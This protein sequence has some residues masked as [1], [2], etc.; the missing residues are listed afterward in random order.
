M[1][2]LIYKYLRGDL[3]LEEQHKLSKWLE[4]DAANKLILEKLRIY[5]NEYDSDLNREDLE[6]R[7]RILAR[8]NNETQL[9]SKAP[10][11]FMR[12]LTRIAA[13]L[14]I[15]LSFGFLLA[16]LLKEEM[17]QPEI[18]WM[19]KTSQP[20]QKITT[21][22][23]DGTR[24]KLNSNSKLFFPD[25]FSQDLRKVI[26]EG[27]AFFDVT[28]DE[29]RPFV[30]ETGNMQIRVLGTS[31]LVSAYEDGETE[32]VAVKSGKVEVKGANAEEAIQL[33]RF[34]ITQYLGGNKMEKSTIQ[35]PEAVFAWVDQR[36][37]FDNHSIEEVLERISR[38]YGVEI[39]LEKKLK[40][41]KKYT[42]SFENPTLKQVM[43]ILAFV[44]DFDYEL[45]GNDLTIK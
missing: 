37:L 13:I 23:P 4:E 7:R 26:L 3:N 1:D 43:D 41:Q 42:A 18:T 16:Q 27:E 40:Q 21:I 36:L 12:Y 29:T 45:K 10:I 9:H 14:V 39:R 44:Y 5:W 31:F 8:M 30:I 11:Q 6:V 32:S 22:L 20:G 38:W 35:K 2:Q 33:S 19:E 34:E 25:Q 28:R 17:P 15:S 24:V